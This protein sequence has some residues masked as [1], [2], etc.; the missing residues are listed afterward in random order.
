MQFS[1]QAQLINKKED[2]VTLLEVLVVTA[3]IGFMVLIIA[4]VPT[5]VYLIN[6]SRN[7][8][9]AR[10]IISQKIDVLRK[11]GYVNLANGKTPFTD[12]AMTNLA[13]P[14]AYYQI[15]DCPSNICS[16][17]LKVKQLTV[18]VDWQEKD[19]TKSAEVSTLV[20]E[21]GIGQ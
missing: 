15:E 4:S 20:S 8:S 16:I 17:G 1:Q 11:Q 9:L 18:H 12:P 3:A 19:S 2:G 7:T 21:G 13:K 6:Q 10:D 14:S 5:S